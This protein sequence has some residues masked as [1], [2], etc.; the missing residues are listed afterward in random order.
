MVVLEGGGRVNDWL[1]GFAREAGVALRVSLRC[2]SHLQAAE[3]VKRLGLAAI[4]PD[5]AAQSFDARTVRRVSLPD[6]AQ[7]DRPLVLV[8]SRRESRVRPALN[9]VG[10]AVAKLLCPNPSEAGATTPR[11]CL[12][13]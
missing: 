4:L 11:R 10:R 7:L 6:F 2:S 5:A 8:W 13:G 1:T 9:R 3:A 12:E